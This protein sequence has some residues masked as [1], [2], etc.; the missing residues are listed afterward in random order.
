MSAH[1]ND[2]SNQPHN[3]DHVDHD[4]DTVQLSSYAFHLSLR[5]PRSSTSSAHT[6]SVPASAQQQIP[7]QAAF[8]PKHQSK[9][10]P[11]LITMASS[12]STEHTRAFTDDYVEQDLVLFGFPVT[13]SN[14]LR[15]FLPVDDATFSSWVTRIKAARWRDSSIISTQMTRFVSAIP[16]KERYAP[17]CAIANEILRL[18]NVELGVKYPIE[19][20][21]FIELAANHIKRFPSPSFDTG[22]RSASRS[23]D[24]LCV[25]QPPGR[26]RYEWS[27]LLFT[28]E[29][30]PKK[31][32]GV[33][34]DEVGILEKDS[35]RH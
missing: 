22:G 30:K 28:C 7:T 32:Q 12:V 18:G 8:V 6:A 19:D 34:T 17:F 20:I 24:I 4:T 15:A 2:Q 16:E 3:V 1:P 11:F 29:V 35:D 14:W 9:P 33:S 25:R 13:R 31:A 27:D 26:P 10:T 21:R 5:V 23:P